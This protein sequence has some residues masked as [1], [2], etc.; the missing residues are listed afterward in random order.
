MFCPWLLKQEFT[1]SIDLGVSVTSQVPCWGVSLVAQPHLTLCDPMD[2]S[3]PGSSVHG[4]LQARILEWVAMPS[5]RGSS[6]PRDWTQVSCIAGGVFTVW[7]TSWGEPSNELDVVP[8]LTCCDRHM[9][10]MPLLFQERM[11]SPP[12]PVK[13]SPAPTKAVT[14]S[15]CF[16]GC[17]SHVLNFV[18][19]NSKTLKLK[20]IYGLQC[21]HYG[22]QYGGSLKK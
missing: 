4:F 2:C 8:T 3:L 14:Q 18:F 21:S 9:F 1:H 10:L 22:E 17:F 15:W 16:Y 19:L 5:S 6:W 20:K 11:T 7:V 12:N 13:W